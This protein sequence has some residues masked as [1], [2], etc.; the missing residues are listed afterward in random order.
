M[1]TRKR[2]RS[3]IELHFGG[4]GERDAFQRRFSSSVSRGSL[5]IELRIQVDGRHSESISGVY[6][7][8]FCMLYGLTASYT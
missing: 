3:T 6:K 1:S 5:I 7:K 2:V 4:E 8:P